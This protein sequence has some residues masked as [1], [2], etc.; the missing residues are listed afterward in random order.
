MVHQKQ[1]TAAAAVVVSEQGYDTLIAALTQQPQQNFHGTADHS[2]NNDGQ[3]V[4]GDGKWEGIATAADVRNLRVTIRAEEAVEEDDDRSGGTRTTQEPAPTTTTTFVQ[5]PGPVVAVESINSSATTIQTTPVT[6]TIVITTTVV[7]TTGNNNNNNHNTRLENIP[8]VSTDRITH[9]GNV[10]KKDALSAVAAA[11]VGIS[12][13]THTKRTSAPPSRDPSKRKKAK[14][15]IQGTNNNN[16]SIANVD[17]DDTKA[18]S[19]KTDDGEGE[20][21]MGVEEDIRGNA[22]AA[23]NNATTKTTVTALV[24]MATAA[25]APAAAATSSTGKLS[26]QQKWDTMFETMKAFATK[27]QHCNPPWYIKQEKVKGIKPKRIKTELANWVQEQRRQYREKIIDDAK[28]GKLESIGFQWKLQKYNPNHKLS[29]KQKQNLEE[30]FNSMVARVSDYVKE[31]GH[32]WISTG[33][34]EDE[35]LAG[36]AM[37]VRSHKRTGKLSEERIL[38]LETAGFQWDYKYDYSNTNRMVPI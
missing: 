28:V 35:H 25:T 15:S 13:G 2:T 3:D 1:V 22:I 29:Q 16:R 11:A 10:D 5:V 26:R 17:V 4:D 6:T 23:T 8:I 34:K 31:H 19:G 32:G 7:V 27:H 18:L 36:W 9:R 20:D 12:T 30:Q 37:R 24:K 38:V 14:I 33:Y 21:G